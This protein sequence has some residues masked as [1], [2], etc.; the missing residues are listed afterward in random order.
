MIWNARESDSIFKFKY[1]VINRFKDLLYLQ[2]FIIKCMFLLVGRLLQSDK[3]K[4]LA[5]Y[6]ASFS[7]EFDFT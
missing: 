6:L 2:V 3:T 5:K 1:N 4:A 7:F